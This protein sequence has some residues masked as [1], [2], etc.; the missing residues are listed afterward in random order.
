MRG[1]RLSYF[2]RPGALRAPGSDVRG[3]GGASRGVARAAIGR[4]RHFAP[5]CLETNLLEV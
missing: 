5:N 1:E 3:R 4:V 2:P